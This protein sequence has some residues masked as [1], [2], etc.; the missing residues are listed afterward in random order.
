MSV[1]QRIRRFVALLERDQLFTSRDLLRFGSRSSIDNTIYLLIRSGMIIRLARGVFTKSESK[2][3]RVKAIEIA[4]AKAKAYKK[5]L[6]TCGR[7]ACVKTGLMNRS[8]ARR[9]FYTDGC[10]S[11]FG[12]VRG[13][14]TLRRSSIRKLV[15][16]STKSGSTLLGLWS[17]KY[18]KDRKSVV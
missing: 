16:G 8:H 7:N 17:L 14:I 9:E 11:S 12:S 13:R 2:A 5:R 3:R 6:A 10:T 18:D 1:I 4:K 15:L